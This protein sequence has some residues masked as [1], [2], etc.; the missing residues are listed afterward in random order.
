MVGLLS[1]VWALF[2]LRLVR[3][4]PAK[5]ICLLLEFLSLTLELALRLLPYCEMPLKAFDD[6][7]RFV[8]EGF[9]VGLRKLEDL[10]CLLDGSRL[11]LR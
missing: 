6:V 5:L 1:W 10:Y 8:S 4:W 9:P 11:F 2:W 7:R 3:F